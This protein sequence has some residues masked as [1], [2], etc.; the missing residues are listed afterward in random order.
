MNKPAE[1][2]LQG[3]ETA[4]AEFEALLRERPGIGF[5]DAAIADSCGTLRGKRIAVA[6][7]PALFRHGMQIPASL[8]LMDARGEMTNAGGHGFG[9]G[10]PDGTA[11][12]VPGTLA[13][14]WGTTPPRA[15]MLMRF[16]RDDGAPILY[17][18][19]NMLEGVVAKFAMLGLF[20]VA[21]LELEFYLIDPARDESGAPQ[22][23]RDP[24]SGG[25]ESALSVYGLDDLDRYGD[26]L[27][28]LTAAARMQNVPV[29][30]VSA[31]YGPGQ[32]ETNLRHGADMLRAADDAIL[33]RQI[34]KNAALATGFHVTF[35]AKP[36]AAFVGSGQ[37]V[38][39][40]LLDASGRNVFDNGTAEGSE[41]LR[42]AAGGLAALMDESMAIFAPNVNDYRRFAPDMF[43]P[44]NRRLGFNNRSAGL[45]VPIS[46]ATA[47]RIEHRCAGADANPYLVLAAVLSGVHHGITARLD[48]GAPAVGNVSRERDSSLPAT[49][50]D[51][52]GKMDAARVLPTYLGADAVKLYAENKRVEMGRVDPLNPRAEYD[53]YL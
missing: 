47:R 35:M 12:P 45:R 53:W 43:A 13:P 23:P 5:V 9:D 40:S 10:D 44:V 34:V 11:W 22:P 38:H 18:A 21:A 48:P 26:F 16:C 50:E 32:F 36:Y 15:Q 41:T 52:L 37:H 24:R 2:N 3:I 7:V 4:E 31:E 39:V 30:G 14:V 8:P 49:L 42:F 19:R 17:D 51:A 46:P 25:R 27:A 28:A 1:P 6:D 33:L 29:S 20:P